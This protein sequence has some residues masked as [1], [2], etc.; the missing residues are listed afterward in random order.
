[1]PDIEHHEL[2]DKPKKDSTVGKIL[3][4]AKPLVD[5]RLKELGYS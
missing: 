2:S 4:D 5:K 3:A 1:M